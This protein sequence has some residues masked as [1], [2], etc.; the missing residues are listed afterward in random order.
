[1]CSLAHSATSQRSRQYLAPPT[2]AGCC[3]TG[4]ATR[5]AASS[6]GEWLGRSVSSSASRACVAMSQALAC[7]GCCAPN[8]GVSR[9]L[10]GFGRMPPCLRVIDGP[11]YDGCPC[12]LRARTIQYLASRWVDGGGARASTRLVFMEWRLT[13]REREGHPAFSGPTEGSFTPTPPVAPL[14]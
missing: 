11:R 13:S 5:R 12:Q 8:L 1:M 6:A 14:T 4:E 10:P 7:D 9:S 2:T 3:V